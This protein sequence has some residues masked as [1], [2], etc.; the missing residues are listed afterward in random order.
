[1]SSSAVESW[2][3]SESAWPFKLR[4]PQLEECRAF[5][6][7]R[8]ATPRLLRLS[9]PSG[10]GKSFLI[11]ELMTQA[12]EGDGQVGLYVDIPPSDLEAS[13]F[14]ERV[15]WLLS[16]ER[17]ASRDAP[18]FVD[19]KTARAW[20][21]TK[22]G[23]PS[24]SSYAYAA[25]RD[26]SAQI[27]VVGPFI[28]PLL[29]ET[30]PFSP[31]VGGVESP[32]RFLMKRSRSRPVLLAIDNTQFLP[33][34]VRELIASEL[35]DGGAHLRLVLIER[36][37]G[38]FRIDWAPYLPGAEVMDLAL[39]SASLD[40]VRQL[41]VQ[42]FPEP[43]DV[44]AIAPIVF[45]RSEGN[46]KSVW[47]QLRLIASRR[48]D[49]EALPTSYEGVIETLRP[50]DQAVLR[51][52]VFTIGGLTI[53][54]LVALLAA[55]DL[56]LP[57]DAVISAVKDLAALGLLVVNGESA[58]RVRV[59]HEL[60]AQ[61]VTEITPEE[62]KLELRSQIVEALSVVL[63][64][65][66]APA[67]QAVLYDRLLGIV[68]STEL[69]QTPSLM[70]HLVQFIQMQSDQERYGYLASVCRDSVC[71][72]V[73][74]SLPATTVRSLLDAIQKSALFSF[75]LIATERLRQ[76][77]RTHESLASL[78][79]AK[80]LVQLFCYDEAAAVLDRVDESKEKRAVEFNITLNLA[81]DERAAEI[82]MEVYGEL[83]GET[84]GE[85]DYLILRN[86]GHLFPPD[87]AR[88]LLEAAVE[89]F[90][91]LGRRFGVATALNCLGVV[92]LGAGAIPRAAELF[93][94]A[95]QQL[96]DLESPEIYGPL[97][98]LGAIAFLQGDSEEAERLIA[99]ARDIAPRSLL[100]DSAMFA[101]NAIAVEVGRE[102]EPSAD[103]V[104]K[105]REVALAARKTRDVRF[106]DLVTWFAEC[107]EAARSDSTVRETLTHRRVTEFRTSDRVPIEVFFTKDVWGVHLDIPYVLSP[108]WRY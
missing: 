54:N 38:R 102:G 66:S 57:A 21:S 104:E 45:R 65:G 13:T 12:G 36:V 63:D 72:D 61:V 89:G 22:R 53:A 83:T 69:R 26:L 95:R 75:G 82:A 93:E 30:T 59:E 42:V 49:Q 40:E 15:D 62:D 55:T 94:D 50:L 87:E 1:V 8:H 71:W 67:E 37:F 7:P 96:Q 16:H 24:S 99:S 10:S 86:S 106:V 35:A 78:Y 41:V 9:G 5:L 81:Q 64:R 88:T 100:Q 18:S 19:K 25:S 108:N 92:E 74:D 14:F 32:L 103:V 34:A 70:A 105:T 46:L 97:V 84:G 43:D 4:K 44:D 90:R 48:K 33:Y 107:L 98:N 47:F 23:A 17:R 76:S 80:Y 28:K 27:P 31:V 68:H 2:F 6:E 56:R 11:R 51:F 73:L 58:D 77:G 52:I 79:E 39:G 60:V 101:L 91:A 85:Q 29:P 20:V 3:T